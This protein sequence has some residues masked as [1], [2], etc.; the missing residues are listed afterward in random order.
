MDPWIDFCTWLAVVVFIFV[1]LACWAWEWQAK[2]RALR[3][4]L[5]GPIHL[6]A[7]SVAAILHQKALE[8]DAIRW[9]LTQGFARMG[10]DREAQ[11]A[12]VPMLAL[13]CWIEENRPSWENAG[14]GFYEDQ[15]Q[16]FWSSYDRHGV[17]EWFLVYVGPLA[18][19]RMG[20]P[21]KCWADHFVE[22]KIGAKMSLEDACRTILEAVQAV[23]KRLETRPARA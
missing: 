17:M 10:V 23:A 11:L 14:V 5:S 16:I 8:E 7:P 2:L 1:G 21:P 13:S 15:G 9:E 6:R 12:D 19:V 18:E 22:V 4:Q 20:V 3:G